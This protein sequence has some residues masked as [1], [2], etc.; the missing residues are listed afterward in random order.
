[1]LILF[2]KT[3]SVLTSNHDIEIHEYSFGNHP[4]PKCKMSVNLKGR[5]ILGHELDH[6]GLCHRPPAGSNPLLWPSSLI[7]KLV[8]ER[9]NI[10]K[11]KMIDFL[12]FDFPAICPPQHAPW[13]GKYFIVFTSQRSRILK[14]EQYLYLASLEG[15]CHYSNVQTHPQ[16]EDTLIIAAFDTSQSGRDQG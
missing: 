4:C 7:Y 16:V 2:K 14:Q 11:Y 9:S 13:P 8:G 5:L 6:N 15:Y 1:M 10:P 3:Q 12:W